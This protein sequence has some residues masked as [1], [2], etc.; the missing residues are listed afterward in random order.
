M[1]RHMVV[2]T[3]SQSTFVELVEITGTWT[4][5]QSYAAAT[6]GFQTMVTPNLS[7]DGTRL[8]F[9]ATKAS[10]TAIYMS[11]RTGVEDMF[12][13]P[14]ILYDLQ[15]GDPEAS[16]TLSPDCQRLFASSSGPLQVW[17]VQ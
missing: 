1:Q 15:H 11:T 8:V 3:D 2:S 16:P 5:R 12:P 4:F 10:S 6:W 13:A 17:M 14:A 9:A 7:S